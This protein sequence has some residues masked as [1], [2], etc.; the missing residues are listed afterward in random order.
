MVLSADNQR[1]LR[2]I[3]TGSSVLAITYKDGVLMCCDTKA[4]YGNMCRYV[5]IPR[6]TKLSSTT[7]IACSGEYSDYQYI[8]DYLGRAHTRDWLNT[9]HDDYALEPREYASMLS[10]LTYAKRCK[11]NPLWTSA[12]VAG[13]QNSQRYLG[14]VDMY[15]T[16]YE[17]SYIAT[18]MGRYF[19]LTLLRDQHKPDMSEQEAR[20]LLEQCMRLLFYRDTLASNRIQMCRMTNE[21]VT[22]DLPKTLDSK[23]DYNSWTE[24]SSKLSLAGC[25]W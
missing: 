6:I 5:D 14:Y 21:G 23:W 8:T 12:I 7:A 20:D 19:G 15:G 17:E 22:I 16:I 13:M 1:T 18:G 2:P 3:V 25:S 24:P 9:D 10:R 11:F 4:S